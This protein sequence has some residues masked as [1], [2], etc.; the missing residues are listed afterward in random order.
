MELNLI[1]NFLIYENFNKHDFFTILLK[2]CIAF[3]SYKGG[4][5]K[6][7][8]SSNI[9]ALLTR[10]GLNVLLLDMDVYAPSLQTYFNTSPDKWIND[11]L[12]EVADFEEVVYDLTNKVEKFSEEFKH[13]ENLKM[14]KLFV[15]FSNSSK[16]EIAKLDGAIRSD[17]SKIELLRKFIHIK[18]EMASKKNIDYIIIDTSPGIRYWSINSLA[19]AD[20]ILLSL[21]MDGIDIAGTRRMA[22]EI[23]SSFMKLGVKSYLLLNR[24][25]GYCLPPNLQDYSYTPE[26][27]YAVVLNEQSQTIE[28]L[29]KDLAMDVMSSVPCYCDIQFDSSEFMTVLKHPKHPFTAKMNELIDKIENLEMT[30]DNN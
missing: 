25:A 29:K 5:G 20:M 4:T 12:F 8:M 2:K 17:S 22:S 30:G 28:K 11:F 1:L 18:E 7:T 9:A 27:N 16:N 21:K 13:N 15:S 14:G 3:H 6:S 24:V 23:Y 10:R 26:T 19:I